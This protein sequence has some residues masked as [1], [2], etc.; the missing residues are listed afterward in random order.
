MLKIYSSMNAT[1]F[2]VNYPLTFFYMLYMRL[3]AFYICT[4][5]ALMLNKIFI[6]FV[7]AKVRQHLINPNY[8]KNEAK[9][10]KRHRNMVTARVDIVTRD[11]SHAERA[12]L[13]VASGPPSESLRNSFAGHSDDDDRLSDDYEGQDYGIISKAKV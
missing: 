6:N 4:I 12:A 7:S 3:Q 8:S 13:L 11:V 5:V 10:D 9:L 1:I 2:L